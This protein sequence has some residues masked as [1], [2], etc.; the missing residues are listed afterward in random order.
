MDVENVLDERR[1]ALQGRQAEN[2]VLQRQMVENQKRMDAFA[3]LLG[4]QQESLS[5]LE[6]IANSRR[7]ILKEKL[8]GIIT[9][10][11][12]LIYGD[13]YSVAF[14]YSMKHNRSSLDIELVKA[15]NDGEVRRGI[16]GHGGGVSDC[17]SV[18]LRLMVLL[19]S[20]R[21]D[22][23]CV[24]DEPFKHVDPER[25]ELVAQFIREISEKLN[26]QVFMLSHHQTLR[27]YADTVYRFEQQHGET[28]VER[29]K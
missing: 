12:H 16:D 9:E 25:V 7:N 6:S 8:E 2:R 3:V 24:L 11:L 20:N 23:V 26:L 1:T 15:T 19:A 5:L 22:K 14:T 13:A 10:A 29:I 18:P 21:V 28:N 27:D 17:I 4:I